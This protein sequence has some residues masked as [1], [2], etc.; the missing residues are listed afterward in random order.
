MWVPFWFRRVEVTLRDGLHAIKEAIDKQ[1]RTNRDSQKTAEAQWREVPGII[2]AAVR[3]A[4]HEIAN[5][6]ANYDQTY[7]QQER[8]IGV[9]RRLVLAT[10]CAFAAAFIYAGIAAWQLCTSQQQ[11]R[12]MRGQGRLD[13]RAWIF[14]RNIAPKEPCSWRAIDFVNSGHT[15][16]LGFTIRAGFAPVPKG[17]PPD[18]SEQVLT[19]NGIIAPGGTYSSCIGDKSI[20]RDDWTKNDLF[21][22][23]RLDYKD[24]FGIDHWT[25][26]CYK[27]SENGTF[28]PY[29]TGNDMDYNGIE[30]A[31]K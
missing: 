7:R 17:Q 14:V 26:F 20:D 15:P 28:V 31:A 6:Q 11:L 24:V 19:G 27:R 25:L 23:G 22:H 21:V 9:Q 4:Q 5:A 29:E 12:V 30:R 1:E 10:W 8:A 16:A 18:R 13:E 2:T 3:P